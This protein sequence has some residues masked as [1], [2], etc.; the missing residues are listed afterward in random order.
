[1]QITSKISLI[2]GSGL[3]LTSTLSLRVVVET[4]LL[5]V[6]DKEERGNSWTYSVGTMTDKLR[7]LTEMIE[8]RKV[9]DQVEEKQVWQHQRWI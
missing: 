5:L 9:E 7:K 3:R 1:M 4:V 8:R 6:K 2:T